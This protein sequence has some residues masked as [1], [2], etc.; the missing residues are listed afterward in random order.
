M[1]KLFHVAG[2]R[3]LGERQN[4]LVK[5]EAGELF[6]NVPGGGEDGNLLSAS[7]E[8]GLEGGKSVFRQQQR[9]HGKT[10]FQKA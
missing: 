10:R 8:Q 9:N 7:I 5:L 4:S 6:E 3:D 2:R 1:K